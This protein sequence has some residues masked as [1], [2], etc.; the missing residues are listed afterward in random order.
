MTFTTF[1][2]D[3]EQQGIELDGRFAA[4][5][6]LLITFS[7]AILD[8]ELTD[9]A[10]TTI[11]SCTDCAPREMIQAPDWSA[12]FGATYTVPVADNYEL[13]LNTEMAFADGYLV[14]YVSST[15][16]NAVGDDLFN[17]QDAWERINL[18]AAIRPMNGN[19]ELSIFGRNITDNRRINDY[20]PDGNATMRYITRQNGADWGIAYR[21]NF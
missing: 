5:E 15:Q 1:N 21:Y 20:A 10:M 18:R 7:A 19:W 2:I 13:T 9:Q 6:N 16:S 8:T 3:T 17:F 4:A 11:F 14:N 12:S